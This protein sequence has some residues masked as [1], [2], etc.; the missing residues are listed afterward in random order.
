MVHTNGY[1]AGAPVCAR[2]LAA[3]ALIAESRD[4]DLYNMYEYECSAAA[5]KSSKFPGRAL[6]A[7]ARVFIRAPNERERDRKRE[8]KN[9]PPPTPPPPPG[10]HSTRRGWREFVCPLSASG[11][12]D[13]GFW[14]GCGGARC[15]AA[16]RKIIRDAENFPIPNR[17]Q[18]IS[19]ITAACVCVCAR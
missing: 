3:P 17:R 12:C 4:V 14:C 13:G 5:T 10:T 19:I 1:G 18:R 9:P 2:R 15:L 7:S 6:R 16:S 8:R 11:R